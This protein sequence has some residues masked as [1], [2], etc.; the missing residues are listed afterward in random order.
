MIKKCF[1]MLVLFLLTT[2]SL[3]GVASALVV[4]DWPYSKPNTVPDG[5]I[6]IDFEDR[7]DNLEAV[8]NDIPGVNF[9]GFEMNR[10]WGYAMVGGRGMHIWPY[11][12]KKNDDGTEVDFIWIVQGMYG[13]FPIFYDYI[14]QPWPGDTGAI[15]FND[16]VSHVSFLASIGSQIEMKAYDKNGKYL[17]TSG[18]GYNNVKR[19]YPTGPSNFTQISYTEESAIIHKVLIQGNMNNWIIDE[20]VIGGLTLPD[21]LSNYSFAAE[22]MKML[23]GA[24]YQE[25]AWG[26]DIV[27]EKYHTADEIINDDLIY[28]DRYEKN[29]VINN[30]ISD[31]AAILWAF[32]GEGT[33]NVKWFDLDDQLKHSFTMAVYGETQPGDIFVIDYMGDSCYDEIGI[34]I[35]PVIIENEEMD[36]IRI[37]PGAGVVYD[38]TDNIENLY[39]GG[40]AGFVEYFRLP[41]TVKGGHKPF[42]KVPTRFII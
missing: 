6:K 20:L 39:D 22:R 21:E 27:N 41:D 25:D 30:G 16:C 8:R 31:N 38:S 7:C 33:D 5:A 11:D 9:V 12:Y 15:I 28:W 36:I 37:I 3:V 17:G 1:I 24:K 26:Y 29:I 34:I 19:V 4:A 35:T 32:N 42:P 10:H 2:A 14:E 13:A 23:I 18:K 40:S